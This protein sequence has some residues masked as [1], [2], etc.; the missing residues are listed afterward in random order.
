MS[1]RCRLLARTASEPRR[2]PCPD[3]D[4]PLSIAECRQLSHATLPLVEAHLPLPRPHGAI[5]SSQDCMAVLLLSDLERTSPEGAARRAH[6]V[7]QL[8]PSGRASAL[9]SADTSLAAL[10]ALPTVRVEAGLQAALQDQV[11]HAV[12][13]G[14]LPP[15][16]PLLIAADCHDILTY[17]RKKPRK[18]PVKPRPS[19]ALPLA[20]GT[21]PELGTS[22]AYRFLTFQTTRGTPLTV[23]VDPFLPLENLP[24]KL[25]KGLDLTEAR[26]GRSIDLLLYDAGAYS[27]EVILA[28]QRR[29][30]PF[31]IRAPQ[32]QRIAALLRGHA[33]LSCFVLH[34]FPVLAQ[35]NRAD[36][37]IAA[38][39]LVG[40]KREV[41]DELGIDTPH[42]ERDVR[43]FTFLTSLTPE[44][45]ESD[46]DYAL[47]VV[48]LYKEGWS[49]ETGYRG[50]EELRGFTHALHYDM[51]LL[52]YF[53][54][55]ILSNVW[56]MQRWRSGKAW[57]KR[58]VAEFLAFAL[59]FALHAEGGVARHEIQVPTGAV[60]PAVALGGGDQKT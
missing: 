59:L 11:T 12:A 28:L 14:A 43:W 52:Q 31:I 50:H 32:N 54:A 30:T 5:Y 45:G 17:H 26:L 4:N 35:G 55:V 38:A 41:L 10:H 27:N 44:P 60:D 15:D 2:R 33:G 53:L 46:R 21:K 56:A 22:L 6:L 37:P 16:Q 36:D 8:S 58:G 3:P 39:T 1:H 51:R 9:P 40:L 25:T 24:T 20:V 13:Q 29:G 7:R 18:V 19:K 57:T 42:T 49:V 48:R 47:R 34:D 23:H